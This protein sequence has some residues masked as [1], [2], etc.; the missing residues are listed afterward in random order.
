ML[1]SFLFPMKIKAMRAFLFLN[2]NTEQKK[3]KCR[4]AIDSLPSSFEL[5]ARDFIVSQL[6]SPRLKV[7]DGGNYDLI[8]SI[9][10]DGTLVSASSMAYEMDVPILGINAGHRGKLCAIH[11]D[12]D[13]SVLDPDKFKISPRFGL[14][15]SKNNPRFA[16]NDVVFVSETRARSVKL[17]I[18]LG[19]KVVD[20]QGDGLIVA[21]PTGSTAYSA[22]LGGPILEE[23]AH[24]FVITPIAPIDAFV[25]PEVV[26]NRKL[27]IS[28]RHPG[29]TRSAI[30][31]DGKDL[32]SFSEDIEVCLSD[33]PLKLVTRIH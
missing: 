8:I 27:V 14:I 21:S 12:D 19:D 17:T 1:N 24:C 18:H 4:K 10:G 22:S 26:I 15:F 11:Y 16:L 5:F 2:T 20:F 31:Y 29:K 9:G 25:H 13:L 7:E 3:E 33:R 23:E 28:P 6:D 32:G 30:C